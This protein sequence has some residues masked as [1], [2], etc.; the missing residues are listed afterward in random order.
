MFFFSLI[1]LLALIHNYTSKASSAH[2]M[3]LKEAAQKKMINDR[4]QISMSADCVYSFFYCWQ[5]FAGVCV[6]EFV[7]KNHLIFIGWLH[8]SK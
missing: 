6:L 3:C 5:E 4:K 2:G 1:Y 7:L 8:V